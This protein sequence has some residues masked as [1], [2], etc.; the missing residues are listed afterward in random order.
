MKTLVLCD[1]YWHPAQTIRQGLGVL[2]G[3]GFQFNWLEDARQWSAARMGESPLVVLAKSNNISSTDET[4]WMTDETQSAFVDY[5]RRGNGLLA[6][7][8]GTAGYLE[9]PLLRS[10]LGGVFVHHPEQCLVHIEPVNSHPLTAG[11][12]A[13]AAQDEHYFMSM[14]DPGVDIFLTSRSAHGEQP[15]GWRRQEGQGRVAVL[16]PGHTL[17]AWLHPSFQTL[18]LNSLRWCAGNHF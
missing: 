2:E 16:T 13:F 1:D 18:L 6:I 12:E 8:S 4:A 14:S 5:V 11:V 7:H 17:E 9:T 15:A 10:L 3:G